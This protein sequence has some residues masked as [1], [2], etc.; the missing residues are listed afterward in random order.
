MAKVAKLADWL[1]AEPDV[2]LLLDSHEYDAEANDFVPGLGL[3][4]AT[5]VRGALIAAGIAPQR[6]TI[7]T[8]GS[9]RLLCGD[10]TDSCRALNRRVEVFAARW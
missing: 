10:A 5:A 2:T 9:Q 1:K 3:R 4:R 7:G 6:L 8:L